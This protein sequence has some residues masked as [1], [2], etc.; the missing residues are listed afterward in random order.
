[1]KITKQQLR[2]IIKEEMVKLEE[3]QWE[4]EH[5]RLPGGSYGRPSSGG[6]VDLRPKRPSGL[7]RAECR[8]QG[9]DGYN[10]ERDECWSL[11]KLAEEE[12]MKEV[13]MTPPEISPVDEIYIAV[14]KKY[15]DHMINDLEK[16]RATPRE[17]WDWARV[18]GPIQYNKDSIARKLANRLRVELARTPGTVGGGN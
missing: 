2:K 14:V 8:K 11:G 18:H 9:Y 4:R 13:E 7:N 12:L 6:H 3:A 17:D 5:V 1:M 10:A 16:Q 15:L